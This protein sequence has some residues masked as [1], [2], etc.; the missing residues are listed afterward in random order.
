MMHSTVAILGVGLVETS[1]LERLL[2]LYGHYPPSGDIAI[3][4]IGLNEMGTGTHRVYQ[5]DHLWVNTVAFQTPLF[6]C[7]STSNL[8]VAA[9]LRQRLRHINT[10]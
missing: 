9:C 7:K 2:T 5:S 8:K 1:I 4:L 6:A 3:L 10:V